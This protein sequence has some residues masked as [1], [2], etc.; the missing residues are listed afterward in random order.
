M[1]NVRQKS[2]ANV[3]KAAGVSTAT[4]SRVLNNFPHVRDET[5]RRVREAVQALNYSPLRTR[6][7]VNDEDGFG[8]ARPGR[9]GNIAIIALGQAREWLQ[10]PVM[11]AAVAGIRN[12]VTERGYRLVLDEL[13]DATKPNRLIDRREIDGAIVFVTGSFPPDLCNQALDILSKKIPIV[14]AM[15]EEYGNY[16]VDH[17]TCDNVHIGHL[18]Y[19]YLRSK[20]CQEIALVALNPSWFFMRLRAQSFLNAA[21]DGGQPPTAFVVSEDPM[22]LDSYGKRVVAAKNAE[23]VVSQILAAERRPDGIFIMN[24]QSTAA[25]VPLLNR[26]GIRTERDMMIVSCDNEESRLAALPSRPA[27]IDIRSEEVGYRAMVR[28]ASRMRN[29][30]ETPLV[31]RVAA[32]LVEA[33]AIADAY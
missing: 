26:H 30:E 31:V 22:L 4:V 25:I 8:R 13:L 10:L 9:T 21:Y 18:A 19:N 6:R 7:D 16:D 23:D 28:L 20:R 32:K 33:G 27:T 2:I 15:G 3:A 11:A 5:I 29:P 24:D 14:W 1:A 12:A 17:V